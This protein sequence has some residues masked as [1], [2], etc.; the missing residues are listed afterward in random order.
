MQEIPFKYQGEAGGETHCEDCWAL[1][2]VAQG[3]CEAMTL[4]SLP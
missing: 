4:S 2:Q 3:G 1:E